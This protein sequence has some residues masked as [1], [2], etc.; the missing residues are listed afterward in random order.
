MHRRTLAI[1]LKA[2]G[3]AH[4]HT[5]TSYGSLAV[6]LHHQGKY[7]EA[8]ATHRR[9]LAIHLKA[10]G[11]GQPSTAAS[12]NNLALTL[13][14]QGKYAEA[15]AMHRRA[16]SVCLKALGE[17]HP[18]TATSYASLAENL[19]AQGKY[20]EAEATHRRALAI[21]LKVQGEGH[22]DTA[23]SY[24]N[25]AATL[26]AQGKD[27]EAEA[28]LRRA[29][30]IWLEAQA[31]G[32][33]DT[34]STYNN[35]ALTLSAQG[36]PAEA[37][38][39]HR[40]AVAIRLKALGEGHPDTVKDYTYLAY[41]LDFQGKHEEA[42]HTWRLAVASDEQ[43]RLFGPKG[44]EAGLGDGSP[45][46]GLA[47]ALARAGQPREAWSNWERG[48]ARGIADEVTRRA[49]RPL[50]AE[51]R[52]RENALLGRGQVVDER[53]NKL[54]G[55]RALTQGQEK[56]LDD[57]RQQASEVRRELLDLERQ[58][59]EKY[60]ALASR[61]ATLEEA[62]RALP[63]G[64]ALVGWIDTKSEHWACLLGRSGD[65]AW[66][67]L[68]GSGKEAALTKQEADLSRS[69]RSELD[70][71]T[72]RGKAG[73][74]AELLA[75]QRLDPLKGH[76]AGVRRLIVVNSPGLTGVPVE[77]LLAARPD[78]AW[79]AITVSY[80]PSAAMFAYLAGRPVPRDRPA[81]LLAVAD[82]AYPEP[83]GDAPA[84]EP[85]AA[86]LAVA[87]VVPNGNADLNGI[88][89]GDVLL[90]YGGTELKQ[91][92]DLKRVASDGGPKKVPVKY[93]REGITREIEL[94]AVP[95]GVAIDPRPAA[96]VVRA[97]RE[98]ERILLGMRGGSHARLP[99]TRREVEA[100]AALF[101][102]G[103]ATTI[104]GPRACESAVQGLARSGKLKSYRYLHFAT[105]GQ[106]D[107]RYAYRTA[108]ILAP[109]PDSSADPAATETDGTITA[110][111]IARTWELDA[112][113]VVLSACES[114][115]GLAAGA[116]GYLG[117]AQPLFVR[118]ARSLVLS[119][120][121]VDDDATALLMTRFY[122]NL[123]GKREGL[124]APMPKAEA[125]AEAKRWLRGAD[126]AEA[127]AALAALPRGTIVRRE[128]AKAGPSAHP[129]EDPTYW[130]GFVLVG[131]PD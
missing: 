110:E 7:A 80:A 45:L 16:L 29:L 31:E 66:V 74:L 50:T 92:G 40:R 116:E 84:P 105:H 83:K 112:D 46:P 5:A 106:S 28:M 59:E 18:S 104:L 101:P 26:R 111:Q 56:T 99:G 14:A 119:Q 10:Q 49:V 62:Q 81:T 23:A 60:G 57:L 32:H 17:G 34:A 102:G 8:E 22:P 96:A 25:L 77:V 71:E 13:D 107:P 97:R 24:H 115:L 64:T 120:W 122:R 19:G 125:L 108:L 35:L 78:P 9:A 123:L 42:L 98:S 88:R 53:I 51:E 94:A 69:L 38:A 4:P 73:T 127:G 75:R 91:P 41:S 70:P 3:E 79:D 54:L 86:G 47:A 12:Y 6:N 58:F 36:K 30:A 20:A 85:P 117:F 44:L 37:E 100:L 90:S 72:T 68:A 61:P 121:K 87:R 15:E 55:A 131:A 124:K 52:D 103:K 67:R 27:A 76:L 129:Y 39:M 82:P 95:L 118:G 109:D 114:G 33:P 113:L 43:A 126:R 65:P 2:H 63:E 48:L 1:M 21:Y 11:E 130:A 93:W 128:A 89:D